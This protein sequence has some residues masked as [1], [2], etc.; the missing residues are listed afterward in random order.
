VHRSRP[1]TIAVPHAP[2]TDLDR[3]RALDRLLRRRQHERD[4][5]IGD[6]R[7]QHIGRVRYQNI[8]SGGGVEVDG[9]VT[10]DSQPRRSVDQRD[11][12]GRAKS[13]PPNGFGACVR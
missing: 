8:A 1:S 7:G 11:P 13:R 2:A 6:Y 9:I 5:E 4:R 3:L 12:G 10:A